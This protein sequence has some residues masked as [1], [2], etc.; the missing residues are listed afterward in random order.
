[1]RRFPEPKFFFAAEWQNWDFAIAIIFYSVIKTSWKFLCILFGCC[2]TQILN[3]NAKHNVANMLKNCL[4]IRVWPHF[5]TIFNI[6]AKLFF[7]LKFKIRV[8]QHPNIMHMK[9]LLQD[10]N[11]CDWK[12]PILSFCSKKMLWLRKSPHMQI[13][14]NA[15]YISNF[16]NFTILVYIT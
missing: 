2:S 8:L 6:F 1:M 12:I 14:T 15:Q 4:K 9:F 7:A 11:Y 10:K 13:I 3:F 5:R 16:D